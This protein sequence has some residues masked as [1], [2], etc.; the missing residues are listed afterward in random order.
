M[1]IHIP[2]LSFI[3]FSVSTLNTTISFRLKSSKI[4]KEYNK[5]PRVED[6]AGSHQI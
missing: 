1:Q 6:P 4:K 3:W 2:V 5:H